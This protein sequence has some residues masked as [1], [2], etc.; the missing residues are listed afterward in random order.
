MTFHRPHLLQACST[1]KITEDSP[2]DL[3][4]RAARS[5]LIRPQE[6][7]QN[8]QPSLERLSASCDS[9]NAYSNVFF[10]AEQQR[11]TLST[12]PPP[13]LAAASAKRLPALC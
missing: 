3:C 6:A 13:A 9:G 1:K 10:F 2:V 5:V 8:A 12:P 4:L 7:H 11:S